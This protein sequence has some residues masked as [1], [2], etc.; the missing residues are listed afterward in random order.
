MSKIDLYKGECLEAIS[1]FNVSLPYTVQLEA[2]E[3][4]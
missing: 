2:R 3:V 4:F 1:V